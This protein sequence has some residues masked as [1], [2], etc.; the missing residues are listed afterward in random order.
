MQTDGRR[1]D[2]GSN[3]N[4]HMMLIT[5]GLFFLLSLLLSYLLPSIDPPEAFFISAL[6]ASS[7]F[8]G[9]MFLSRKSMDEVRDRFDSMDAKLDSM[10]ARLDSIDGKL[11]DII[12]TQVEMKDILKEIRDILRERLPE[13]K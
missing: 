12:E 13:R 3:I 10:D 7:F 4:Y 9:G 2:R 11:D 1:D 8:V 5:I 6:I